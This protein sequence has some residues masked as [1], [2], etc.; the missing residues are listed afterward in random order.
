MFRSSICPFPSGFPT[1][2]LYAFLFSPT[3]VACPAHANPLYKISRMNL[4][5]RYKSRISSLCNFSSHPFL[6]LQKEIYFIS[7]LNYSLIFQ[8]KH[9][10][11]ETKIYDCRIYY[12]RGFLS[13]N[14]CSHFLRKWGMRWRSG[15]D[16]ALQTGRSRVRF[17]MVSLK[18]FIDI[19]LLA[20]LW[21]WGWLSLLTK[22][23][24]RNNSWGVKVASA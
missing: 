3:P 18:I 2:T 22:M 4:A 12:R 11:Q 7:K 13:L 5:K 19:I 24:T 16:T 17:P 15:W 10:H 1:K 14:N 23:S 20:A 9:I 8:T 6:P 21:P